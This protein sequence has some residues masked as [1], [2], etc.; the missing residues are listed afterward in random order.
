M[1]LAKLAPLHPSQTVQ[2]TRCACDDAHDESRLFSSCIHSVY[3]ASCRG[4]AEALERLAARD[5]WLHH[6]HHTLVVV[7][8]CLA[9]QRNK[10]TGDS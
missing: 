6:H 10:Q 5:T 7:P 4:G 8:W 3:L 2:I 1:G 9:A